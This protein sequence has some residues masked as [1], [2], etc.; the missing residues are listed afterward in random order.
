MKKQLIEE[1][2]DLNEI[3]WYVFVA[4]AVVVVE[5]GRL[6]DVEQERQKGMLLKEVEVV[7]RNVEVSEPPCQSSSC[8]S[9]IQPTY[10]Q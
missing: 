7:E 6:E 5:V 10:E 8:P 4:A 2:E 3:R 9:Y 1:E